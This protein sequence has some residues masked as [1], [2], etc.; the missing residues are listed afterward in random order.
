LPRVSNATHVHILQHPR[1]RNRPIGTVR[2]AHLGLTRCEVE[3]N[4][5]WTGKPSI[6]AEN[7]PP[8]AALLF[9]SASARAIETLPP[10]ERPTTLI[11][12]DGT[13]HQV[14]ALVRNNQWLEALPHV[15]LAEPAPSRYRIRAEPQADYIS[16]LEAI[17]ATLVHLEPDTTGFE[18]LLQAFDTMI[19]VQIERSLVRKVRRPTRR[20]ALAQPSGQRALPTL[21]SHHPENHVLLHIETIGGHASAQPIQVCA[22]RPGSEARFECLIAHEPLAD[23]RKC[24]RLGVSA[25]AFATAVS[26]DEFWRRWAEFTRA[27]DVFLAWNQRSLDALGQPERAV[28]LKAAWCNLERRRAGHLADVLAGHGLQRE[29]MDFLGNAGA[30]M[31]EA[32]A[33]RRWLLED[34]SA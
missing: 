2:F 19:D 9:P 33:V 10:A 27:D 20:A 30:H 7:P 4:R 3:V 14:K 17:V 5:P 12:L 24:H 25:E 23:A 31:G 28:L 16:T 8:G 22:W 29:S 26:E 11:V 32:R 21:L 1:E 13:W 34:R 18:E 6:L 15:C